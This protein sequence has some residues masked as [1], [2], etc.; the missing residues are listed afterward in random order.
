[1]Q[2]RYCLALDL[3]NNTELIEE[4][5]PYHRNV[6]PEIKD[7]IKASGI[8]AMEIYRFANRL[9]M[10]MEVSEHFSFEDK[11]RSDSENN[12]VQEWETLMWKFQQP[13]PGAPEG[14]KWVLLE[15]IFDLN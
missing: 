14:A 8:V 6:W 7:S 13:L 3:K 4:Y 1:M 10:I 2:K 15:K 9:F 12:K 11:A 5:E